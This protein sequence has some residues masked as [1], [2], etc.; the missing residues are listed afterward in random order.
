MTARRTWV[1]RFL[2]G[3]AVNQG[4][5]GYFLV[6]ELTVPHEGRAVELH[7][8]RERFQSLVINFTA[9]SRLFPLDED[10]T[11]TDRVNRLRMLAQ[12]GMPHDAA[13]ALVYPELD[14]SQPDRVTD[15]E[16]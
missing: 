2:V 16:P 3:R 9:E 4:R 6:G 10:A 11:E 7:I 1:G 15:S 14:P 8:K 12:L 5:E 13:R